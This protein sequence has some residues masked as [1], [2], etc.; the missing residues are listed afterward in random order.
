M[1][2]DTIHD[3]FKIAS[4]KK[5][6]DEVR[7]RAEREGWDEVTLEK[8]LDE[9]GH[10]VNDT[11][12]GLHFDI[13]GFSPKE[14]RIMRALLLSPDWT[15][16]TIRQAL[17][18]FGFGTLYGD[19]GFWKT[20]F[21]GE[22]PT[23]MRKKYGREFW[24]TAFFFFYAFF[25]ALNAWMRI[26]DE[27]EWKKMAEDKRKTDPNYKSPYE[28]AYPDGMKWY[29]Y[30]MLG[31]ALGHKTHLFT[32][33]YEDGTE[34]YLRWG[35]Q[36]RELP[37]LF[38]GRDGF[39]IPY[40]MIEKIAGKAN[41]MLSTSFTVLSG[42]SL[43]GWENEHMK[44]TKGWDRTV[45]ALLVIRDAYLPYSIPTQE[46]KDWYWLDL[47][48]PS[49]KGYSSGKAINGF[50][51]GIK[52]GDMEY[53]RNVYNACIMSGIN[54]EKS[55]DVAKARFEAEGKANMLAAVDN[56]QDALLLF[57]NTTDIQKKKRL[58]RYIEQQIGAQDFNAISQEEMLQKA[59]DVINGESVSSAAEDVYIGLAQEDDVMEDYRMKKN[60][61]GLKKYHQDYTELMMENPTAGRR[62]MEEKRKYLEGY[63]MTTKVRSAINKIKKAMKEGRVEADQGMK[64]IRR[65]RKEYFKAMDDLK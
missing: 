31:N 38:F 32:G 58:I 11:F 15:L 57:G 56:I 63:A 4:F 35:K 46:D 62:M 42:H 29:D 19:E 6:A 36:F 43:S 55:F 3:G 7:R 33:R 45:G 1:L 60:A 44:D 53:I 37:E 26:K 39:S 13:L 65:L 21:A 14:V 54:P 23:K 64:E 17:S 18:P 24:I 59:K 5:M 9:C 8:A 50:E 22:N 10:L 2:W 48:M 40:P 20:I 47:I 27:D 34:R 28:L 30:T 12:G 52:S 25:N 51:K 49:S 41:P 16:A 61:A